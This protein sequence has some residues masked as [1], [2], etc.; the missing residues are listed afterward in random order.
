[1]GQVWET[2]A[3]R[4]QG[5]RRAEKVLKTMEIEKSPEA[6][7]SLTTYLKEEIADPQFATEI[8]QLA[9]QIITLNP[10]E[11]AQTN[12]NHGRDQIVINQP[13][14]DLQIGES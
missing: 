13:T 6:A 14:G 4:F 1:M 3:R 8:R 10:T 9:Q 5:N 7:E 2:I 12:I 11:S